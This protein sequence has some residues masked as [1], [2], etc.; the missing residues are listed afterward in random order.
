MAAVPKILIELG[1]QPVSIVS[2]LFLTKDRNYLFGGVFEKNG[3]EYFVVDI[4]TSIIYF[5]LDSDNLTRLLKGELTFWRF[6]NYSHTH[7]NLYPSKKTRILELGKLRIKLF[8]KSYV[9]IPNSYYVWCEYL[10]NKTQ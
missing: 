3:K 2:V 8:L 5:E 10:K 6:V 4:K 1:F 9:T 7:Y